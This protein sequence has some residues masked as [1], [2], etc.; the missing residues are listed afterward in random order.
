[1]ALNTKIAPNYVLA[2]TPSFQ[3][4]LKFEKWDTEK[5]FPWFKFNKV[6]LV[7]TEIKFQA[8][9]V[10]GLLTYLFSISFYPHFKKNEKSQK[11]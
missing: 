10:L 6:S 2:L 11:M 7:E 4:A 5:K 8:I 3:A 1:M 9:N